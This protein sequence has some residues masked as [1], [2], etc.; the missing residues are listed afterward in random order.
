MPKFD[1]GTA[2]A[3]GRG[4]LQVDSGQQKPGWTGASGSRKIA[5]KACRSYIPAAMGRPT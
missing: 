1:K 3:G 4:V 5:T 2:A